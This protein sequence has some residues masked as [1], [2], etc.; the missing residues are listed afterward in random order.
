[1]ISVGHVNGILWRWVER[2]VGLWLSVPVHSE[3]VNV[4][5][6]GMLIW[7]LQW[8]LFS[9]DLWYLSLKF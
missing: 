3:Y 5:G 1:M 9:G 2:N 7:T 8:V 4:S 6:K